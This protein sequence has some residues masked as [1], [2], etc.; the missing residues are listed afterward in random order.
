MHMIRCSMNIVLMKKVIFMS[1]N[2]TLKYSETNKNVSTYQS[3]NFRNM[4][5][6]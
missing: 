3:F 2:R 1:F 5:N 4:C 6:H